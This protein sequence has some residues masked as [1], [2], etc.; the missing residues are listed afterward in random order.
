[1]TSP[2]PTRI[3]PE[4]VAKVASLARLT[5]TDDELHQA[6]DELGAMLDHFAD[7]DA[8]DLDDVEPMMQPT[9]LANVMRDDVVGVMLDRDEVLAAAPV[10]EDGRFRVPPIIGLDD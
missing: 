4:A 10:A 5:L 3:T 6:T 9:P 2:E 8:L 1:M 7:I